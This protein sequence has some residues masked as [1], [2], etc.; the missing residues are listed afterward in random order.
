MT[1]RLIRKSNEDVLFAYIS[2]SVVK[3]RDSVKF[4]RVLLFNR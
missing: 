2:G 4:K 3:L 1:F